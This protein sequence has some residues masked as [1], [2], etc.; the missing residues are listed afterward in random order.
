MMETG[1]LPDMLEEGEILPDPSCAARSPAFLPTGGDAGTRN[2]QTV[3]RGLGSSRFSVGIHAQSS[4]LLPGRD[5]GPNIPTGPRLLT[6]PGALPGP[7]HHVQPPHIRMKDDLRKQLED[8]MRHG[9][10]WSVTTM[11]QPFAAWSPLPSHQEMETRPCH[12]S[13]SRVHK[14]RC[15]HTVGVARSA[16]QCASNCVGSSAVS[17]SSPSLAL[18]KI[19]ESRSDEPR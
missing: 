4:R 2:T 3:S 8:G 19:P 18:K 7:M 1:D 16:E 15:G 12:C 9:Q 17:L 10:Y 13:K 14:L 5:L 11:P 6:H